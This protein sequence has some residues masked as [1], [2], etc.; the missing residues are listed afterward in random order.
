VSW[1]DHAFGAIGG[2]LAARLLSDESGAD[3]VRP[4]GALT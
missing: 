1:E 2:L 3:P 4:A